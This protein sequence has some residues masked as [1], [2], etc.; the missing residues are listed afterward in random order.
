MQW[1]INFPFQTTVTNKEEILSKIVKLD[2]LYEYE[3]YM[4]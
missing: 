2:H 3:S 4:K 1:V